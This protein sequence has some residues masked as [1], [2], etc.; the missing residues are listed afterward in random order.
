MKRKCRLCDVNPAEKDLGLFY[1][2]E[3]CD[4]CKIPIIVLKEH[5]KDLNE[6][7]SAEFKRLLEKE[8]PEYKSRGIG[9]RT[10]PDHWHEHL[11]R[12]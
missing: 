1:L 6:E 9:M 2:I 5:R 3:K 11:K 4:T 8:F 12:K 7:E 10:I